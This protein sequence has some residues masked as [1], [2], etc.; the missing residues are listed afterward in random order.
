MCRM[1]YRRED[2]GRYSTRIASRE[3]KEGKGGEGREG[4]GEKGSSLQ[5]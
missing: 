2:E 4:K 3:R 1:V 5:G